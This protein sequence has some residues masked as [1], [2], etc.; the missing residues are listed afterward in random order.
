[1]VNLEIPSVLSDVDPNASLGYKGGSGGVR[2]MEETRVPFGN[3]WMVRE[4]VSDALLRVKGECLD[5]VIL[6]CKL[7]LI[8]RFVFVVGLGIFI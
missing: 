8:M 1:M 5:T 6:E 4:G 7:I 3:G 2:D